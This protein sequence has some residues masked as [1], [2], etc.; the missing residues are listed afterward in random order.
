MRTFDHF[1]ATITCPL[2]G[3]SEDKPCTLIPIDGTE[4]GG[5]CE[6]IPVHADCVAN[7]QLQFNRDV[8]VFYVRAI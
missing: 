6:A 7:A 2:C 3:T 8:N 5:N 1:P 4:D